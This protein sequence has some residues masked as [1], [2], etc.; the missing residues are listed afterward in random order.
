MNDF[1]T[2]VFAKIP[3]LAPYKDEL[4]SQGAVYASMSGSGYAFFGICFSFNLLISSI[5]SFEKLFDKFKLKV[6]SL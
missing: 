1:E 5:S 2:T 6:P 4:Y 3:E